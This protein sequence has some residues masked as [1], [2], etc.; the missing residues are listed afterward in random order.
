VFSKA[1]FLTVA[2]AVA[3]R[4][5]A[6][7]VVYDVGYMACSYFTVGSI[8]VRYRVL[9]MPRIQW[10]ELPGSLSFG[11]PCEHAATPSGPVVRAT[12]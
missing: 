1:P 8:E 2:A 9:G 3:T 10:I 12:R 4:S 11:P 7:E 6:R 5:A